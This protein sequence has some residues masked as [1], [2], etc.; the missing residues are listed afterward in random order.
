MNVGV[1]KRSARGVTVSGALLETRHEIGVESGVLEFFDE[2][3]ARRPVQAL[4]H[5]MHAAAFPS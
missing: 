1:E 4:V 5:C 2:R 3:E